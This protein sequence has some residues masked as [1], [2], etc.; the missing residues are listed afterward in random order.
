MDRLGKYVGE[1]YNFETNNC[2]T[3]VIKILNDNGYNLPD[4][5]GFYL[6][7][8][9][10]ETEQDRMLKGL[11]QYGNQISAEKIQRFDIVVFTFSGIPRH[12]G[13]MLDKS[14]FIHI[15]EGKRSI[16]SKLRHYQ[17]FLHSVWRMEVQS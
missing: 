9:W 10:Y 5:D 7:E 8:N 6:P 17:K 14:Q 1:H 11:G 2:L 3:F 4:N 13:L 15:R 16:I 12:M